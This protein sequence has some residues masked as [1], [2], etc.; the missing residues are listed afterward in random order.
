MANSGGLPEL[1]A[2]SAEA[3]A[4]LDSIVSDFNIDDATEVKRIESITRHDVKAVEYFLKDRVK[5]HAELS[6]KA[7]FLHFACT[8]EDIS[9]LAYAMMLR[10]ARETVMVPK[11]RALVDRLSEMAVEHADQPMLCRTHGQPATPSTVGKEMGNFA[12]RLARQLQQFCAVPI[13]GKFNG[14]VGN[15]NAHLSAYPEHDWPA[16]SRR[17]VEESLGL[18]WAQYSTQIECHDYIAE[19]FDAASRFNTVLLGLDRDMWGYVSLGYWKLVTVKGEV[20]SST[21]PHKVNPIDFENSEGNVGV[22]NATLGHLAAKLPVSRFQRDLSDSTVLRT[23]GVGMAH[24][25]IAYHSALLGLSK[26]TVNAPA[27]EADLEANWE[28]LA[29]PIQ[30]VM[31]R[32]SIEGAY[33]QLKELTRGK[34]IDGDS[35][36]AFVA[37]LPLPAEERARLA[38]MTPRTYT[39]AA[40]ALARQVPAAV[41]DLLK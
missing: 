7:E 5:N 14:A 2:L 33:E 9:N 32:Y 40:A 3:N 26:V 15:F 12:V 31:R 11:M 20:G 4:L 1:S 24:S 23:V 21:M 17:F 19:L 29:E 27:L 16:L 39:G 8:S 13:S 30:T 25:L 34:R 6:A 38:A 18:R 10:D 22:A 37:T 35:L 36:R 41:E 28:V